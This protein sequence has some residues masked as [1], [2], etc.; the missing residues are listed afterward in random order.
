MDTSEIY[1]GARGEEFKNFIRSVIAIGNVK[2]KYVDAVLTDDNMKIMNDA[3]THETADPRRNYQ[4]LEILGDSSAN[5]ALVW[6][7]S[8]RFPQINCPDGVNTLARLKIKYGAKKYF[9]VFA[10]KLGM[11]PYISASEFV[12]TNR[13]SKTLEDVFEAFFAAIEKILDEKFL[14]G[15]GY[16]TVYDIIS[17]FMDKVT[18][19][20]E[21]KDLFDAKSRFNETI[22]WYLKE[23][24]EQSWYG[25]YKDKLNEYM[26]YIEEKDSDNKY[27]IRL[28]IKN[29]G[30]SKNPQVIGEGHDFTKVGAEIKAAEQALTWLSKHNIKKPIPEFY[31]TYCNFEPGEY[32][33]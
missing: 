29:I 30:F 3:F 5:K 26:N 31:K 4:F 25:K 28:I 11:W 14:I 23:H 8:R 17:K 22:S 21:Y 13:F 10:N 15:V 1:H 20:L 24:K 32:M 6:Y 27:H 12:R 9:A 33:K 7:F 18:I 19:S 2:A 16:S